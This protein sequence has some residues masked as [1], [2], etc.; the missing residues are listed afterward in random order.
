MF[1]RLSPFSGKIAHAVRGA[2]LNLSS[3]GDLVTE[4]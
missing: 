3:I 4:L 1:E 2:Q